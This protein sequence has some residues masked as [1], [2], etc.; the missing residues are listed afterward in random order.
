MMAGEISS[1]YL[2]QIAKI[3]IVF[4]GSPTVENYE[5]SVEASV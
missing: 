5:V 1:Y 4:T 2:E 3:G